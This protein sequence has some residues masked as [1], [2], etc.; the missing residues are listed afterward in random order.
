MN[1]PLPAYQ[2]LETARALIDRYGLQAGAVAAERA[3][4]AQ[5][6]GE[7]AQLDH[8]RSVAVAIAEL[9]QTRHASA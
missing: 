1:S 4:V 8:W 3:A 5:A 6:G 9:R 7:P 2:P